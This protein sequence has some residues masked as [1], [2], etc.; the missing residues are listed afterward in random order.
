MQQKNG[1]LI[2]IGIFYLNEED[3]PSDLQ[4]QQDI[5]V[6]TNYNLSWTAPVNETQS[7]DVFVTLIGMPY[8]T[9]SPDYVVSNGDTN[10]LLTNLEENAMY[11]AKK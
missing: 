1:N 6:P 7:Y 11:E 8:S 4:V 5:T 10:V 9:T 3:K 2:N